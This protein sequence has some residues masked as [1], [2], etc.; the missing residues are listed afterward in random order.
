MN[1]NPMIQ[2]IKLKKL[3]IK[4]PA[5]VAICSLCGGILVNTGY[6]FLSWSSLYLISISYLRSTLKSVN[7]SPYISSGVS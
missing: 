3:P 7:P 5:T 4:S 1:K 6:F 2:I